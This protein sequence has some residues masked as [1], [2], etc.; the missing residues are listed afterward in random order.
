[1]S[2]CQPLIDLLKYLETNESASIKSI[3]IKAQSLFTEV[4]EN[5]FDNFLMIEFKTSLPCMEVFKSWP[6]PELQAPPSPP[7]LSPSQRPITYK[8]IEE[9][10]FHWHS[11]KY[12]AYGRMIIIGTDNER[13]KYIRIDAKK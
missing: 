10:P 2:L 4:A 12:Q 3:Q 9:N 8:S 6:T 7:P 11:L 5:N 1:M 13:I